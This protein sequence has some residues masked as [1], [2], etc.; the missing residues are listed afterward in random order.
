MPLDEQLRQGGRG[1]GCGVVWLSACRRAAPSPPL[2]IIRF[3]S[4]FSIHR[5]T[6][7]LRL[8]CI[9]SHNVTGSCNGWQTTQALYPRPSQQSRRPPTIVQRG[10]PPSTLLLPQTQSARIAGR[11][12]KPPLRIHLPPSRHRRLPASTPNRS[13]LRKWPDFSTDLSSGLPRSEILCICQS[14][15]TPEPIQQELCY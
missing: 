7:I 8:L 12:A 1:R 3:S 15:T 5:S 11:T 9:S 13:A 14:Y 2:K 4:Y 6:R 10:R